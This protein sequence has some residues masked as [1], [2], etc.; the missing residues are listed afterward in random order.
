MVGLKP[1]YGLVSCKG[2]IPNSYSFDHCGPLAATT[3]DCAI[4]LQAIAGVAEHDY[5]AHLNAGVRGLRIGVLRHFWEEDT[6][7]NAEL[8]A[9]TT[10]LSRSAAHKEVTRLVRE[11]I[12]AL[13]DGKPPPRIEAAKLLEARR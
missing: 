7:I 8:R 11:A 13:R 1:T 9:A 12:E 4:V 2:V 10:G 5:C 3:E 6:Q